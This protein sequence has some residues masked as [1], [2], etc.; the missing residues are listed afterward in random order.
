MATVL[1]TLYPPLIDTF[2][3]AFPYT[4][5][6]SVDFSISSYNSWQEIKYMHI[7]LVNQK[8]NQNA[9]KVCDSEDQ[10]KFSVSHRNVGFGSILGG[11]R[12]WWI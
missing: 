7:T 6:A 1:S 9:F 3:P 2:M 12:K 11:D 8:T 4:G 5:P 10:P